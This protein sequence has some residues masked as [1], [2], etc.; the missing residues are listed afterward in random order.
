MAALLMMAALV[1]G[2][3]LLRRQET[4]TWIAVHESPANRPDATTWLHTRLRQRGLRC[5]LKVAG[6]G[7][8]SQSTT[9]LGDRSLGQS[10]RLLVHEDDVDEAQAFIEQSD[11]NDAFPSPR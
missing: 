9:F 8:G 11:V 5:K 10:Y 7:L 3:V 2:Y 6:T 1:A 4:Q